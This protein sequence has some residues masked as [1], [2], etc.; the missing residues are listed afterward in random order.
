MDP[1]AIVGYLYLIGVVVASVAIYWG[2]RRLTTFWLRDDWA[3]RKIV[4]YLLAF[5]PIL[6]LAVLDVGKDLAAPILAAGALV[7]IPS[8]FAI[9]TAPE[10]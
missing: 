6:A 4:L 3:A 7:I 8:L 2:A 9:L 5:G 1:S 10:Q